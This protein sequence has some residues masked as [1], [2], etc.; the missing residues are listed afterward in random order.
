MVVGSVIV[1]LSPSTMSR[2]FKGTIGPGSSLN[3][4]AS[5]SVLRNMAR[6]FT[7]PTSS[8][9]Q[10]SRTSNAM[11]VLPSLESASARNQRNDSEDVVVQ[12]DPVSSATLS[13]STSPESSPHRSHARSYS[14][15]YTSM[16]GSVPASPVKDN[17]PSPSKQLDPI[18]PSPNKRTP[19]TRTK[20]SAAISKGRVVPR[21]NK[22]QRPS[23][24]REVAKSAPLLSTLSALRRPSTAGCKPRQINLGR[25]ELIGKGSFGM[26]YK[27]IDLESNRLLAV[28][29]IS[30]V[31]SNVQQ[32]PILQKELALMER[33]HHP[34]I[35]QCLGADHD[36]QYLRI[37]MDYVAGG[38][39]S[40]IIRSFGCFQER[41]ASVLT[42]QM[43]RG[44]QYLHDRKIAHRDLKGDNLLLETDGTL[45]LADFGTAKELATQAMSVA[46]TAYFMA[47]EV[48]RGVGHGVEADVWSVG[49]CV[50]E[51]LT[52]K[53]PFSDLKNQYAIMMRVAESDTPL[54]DIYPPHA[55]PAVVHFLNRCIQRD[56]TK[57]ATCA[58]LLREDWIVNPPPA[59]PVSRSAGEPLGPIDDH[60]L[61]TNNPLDDEG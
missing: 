40:S 41:Q 55:S 32:L 9:W 42:Q 45:K 13:S 37:Y 39:V 20:E 10:S 34:N 11:T 46:G 5:G 58:E 14:E 44:L 2:T 12:E 1:M 8:M 22:P 25:R 15:D 49:C 47:P 57:R 16:S 4:S 28:K 7:T 30:L 26:V 48:I 24:Q 61:S 53:P 31:G 60:P 54:D 59:I 33:L 23:E 29:E 3:G 21:S 52:G 27:G 50:I 38:S 51:M 17:S 6:P 56:P 19:K 35:V 36:D 43:L 18:S